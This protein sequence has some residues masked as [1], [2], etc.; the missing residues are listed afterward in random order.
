[1]SRSPSSTV[2]KPR[3]ALK[4]ICVG[5]EMWF[6]V[7]MPKRPPHRMPKALRNPPTTS[8]LNHCRSH[9]PSRKICRL[10][11]FNCE[12]SRFGRV[13]K[14]LLWSFALLAE[15]RESGY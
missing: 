2:K 15:C 3:D 9:K 7:V 10:E 1:M 6:R 8:R 13:T 11:H 4:K 12:C 14:Q 5:A